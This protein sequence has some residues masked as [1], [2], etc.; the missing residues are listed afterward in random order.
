M[1]NKYN[2]LNFNFE[3]PEQTNQKLRSVKFSN[4]SKK[5]IKHICRI[6]IQSY[7][8][9]T[10]IDTLI[11]IR[12]IG[13]DVTLN[14]LQRDTSSQIKNYTEV[15]HSPSKLLMLDDINLSLFK[16]NLFNEYY[17]TPEQN[18]TCDIWKALVAAEEINICLN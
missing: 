2:Y 1:L 16:H 13:Y 17:D 8:D 6:Q 5:I 10:N 9:I 11:E 12:N 7:R 14:D 15:L 18:E 4:K 3:A